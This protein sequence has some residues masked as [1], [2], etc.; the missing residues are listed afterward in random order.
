MF[1]ISDD[2][3]EEVK[4]RV[5]LTSNVDEFNCSSGPLTGNLLKKAYKT[6][7]FCDQCYHLCLCPI[8]ADFVVKHYLAVAPGKK[9]QLKAGYAAH[10]TKYV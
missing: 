10:I 7:R 5:Y 4:K 8:L 1:G 3:R 6:C 2:L 9:S